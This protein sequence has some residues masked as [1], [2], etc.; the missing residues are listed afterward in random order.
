MD[1]LG[2][3]QSVWNWQRMVVSLLTKILAALGG[4]SGVQKTPGL[5]R[6]SAAGTVAAGAISVSIYNAGIANGTVLGSTIKPG[7]SLTWA[8]YANDTLAAIAYDGTGTELVIT[9]I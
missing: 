7:E 6:T 5:T 2:N 8:T 4:G 9:K 3:K 1:N